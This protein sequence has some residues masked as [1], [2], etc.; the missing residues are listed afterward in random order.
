LASGHP[1][2]SLRA[3]SWE[4]VKGERELHSRTGNNLW[5]GPVADLEEDWSLHSWGK[6]AFEECHGSWWRSSRVGKERAEGKQSGLNH[7]LN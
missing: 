1:V 3:L 4:E 6:E 2:S 5:E 7:G